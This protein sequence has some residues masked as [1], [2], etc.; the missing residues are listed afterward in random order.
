MKKKKSDNN[1]PYYW[2]I[3]SGTIQREPPLWS[4]EMPKELKT[5]VT[6]QHF[7]TSAKSP[8]TNGAAAAASAASTFNAINSFYGSKDGLGGSRVQVY[9]F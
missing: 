4:K 2:H 5:P 7:L 8:M 6:T 1:G 3:K 9:D